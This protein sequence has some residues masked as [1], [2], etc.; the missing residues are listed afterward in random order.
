MQVIP[1]ELLTHMTRIGEGSF[2]EV[3]R[4]TYCGSDVA[5]KKMKLASADRSSFE[6]ECNTLASVGSH[7][8]IVR[9]HGKSQTPGDDP[10]LLLV[11]DFCQYGSVKSYLAREKDK[12][13]S[14]SAVG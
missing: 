11:M 14:A 6:R 1:Y 13:V 5:V 9:V 2:G 12:K 8:N 3:F 7:G 4:S 10:A